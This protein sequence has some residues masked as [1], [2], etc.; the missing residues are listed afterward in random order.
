M[1]VTEKLREL[2]Q[3]ADLSLEKLAKAAGY[4]AAS[5][6]QRY[7]N[8]DQFTEEYLPLEF[9]RRIQPVLASK[10]VPADEVMAL[11]GLPAAADQAA[12]GLLYPDLVRIA[13]EALACYL[14]DTGL[15]MDPPDQGRL[16]VLL[17]L[18]YQE[19]MTAG[20][21]PKD[22]DVAQAVAFLRLLHRGQSA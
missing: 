20:R 3:R 1:H 6:I 8:P 13:V 7:E 5:S 18:W 11:A 17:C 10:G 21:Q 12:A 15:E 14:E 2:R 16:V 19:E 4:R 9:V 22:L